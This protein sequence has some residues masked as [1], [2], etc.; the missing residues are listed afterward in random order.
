M[1]SKL[2]FNLYL[3]QKFQKPQNEKQLERHYGKT[4]EN[5]IECDV[6]KTHL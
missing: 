1:L 4:I 5:F 3:N 2:L 6:Q